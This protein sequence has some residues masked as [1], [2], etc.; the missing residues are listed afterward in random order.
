MNRTQ[1]FLSFRSYLAGLALTLVPSVPALAGPRPAPA[2]PSP[3]PPVAYAANLTDKL[4][5]VTSANLGTSAVFNQGGGGFAE[6]PWGEVWVQYTPFEQGGGFLQII[7]H[8][9]ERMDASSVRPSEAFT[10]VTQA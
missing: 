2:P 4:A 7:T 9:H 6:S 10:L 3:R 5:V 1:K 8:P